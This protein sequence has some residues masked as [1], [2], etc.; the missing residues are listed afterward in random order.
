M[1]DVRVGAAF[2]LSVL[3]LV[4]CGGG[5]PGSAT[6][7][8]PADAAAD[9]GAMDATPRPVAPVS[10]AGAMDASLPPSPL[11]QVPS[12][13][14]PILAHP[15]L[16]TITFQGDP[17]TADLQAFGE[18]LVQSSWLTTVGAEYGVGA[19]TQRAKLVVDYTPPA[20]VS[21]S[22]I[23]T[24]L[25]AG[26]A[27]GVFPQPD[28]ETIYVIYYPPTT[29]PSGLGCD[30]PWWGHNTVTSPVRYAYAAIPECPPPALYGWSPIESIEQDASHEIIESA[31]DPDRAGAPSYAITDPENPFLYMGSEIADLCVGLVTTEAGFYAQRVWSNAAA[32]AGRS[33]CVPAPAGDT[34]FEMMPSSAAALAIAAG[35]SEKVQL[36]AWS[37]PPR[38]PWVVAAETFPGYQATL[39]P[40]GT[41]DVQTVNEGDHATLTVSVP[42]GATSGQKGIL[43]VDSLTVNPDGM[44]TGG[45]YEWPILVQVP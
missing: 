10:D 6:P 12:Q 42:A 9:A 16:V 44:L 22:D 40:T 39:F 28:P 30:G 41:L 38:G 8:P 34:I 21:T 4:G 20:V 29:T 15:E 37:S 36:T 1:F 18:W 23:E 45:P 27:M 26:I 32:A 14:G 35:G 43:V 19:G 33:P 24:Y 3:A 17:Y 31:T 7:A 5:S 11:P 2:A 25:S 13:G